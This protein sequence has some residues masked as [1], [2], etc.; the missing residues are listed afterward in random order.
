MQVCFLIES[1]GDLLSVNTRY[2]NG[3]ESIGAAP[4]AARVRHVS[5]KNGRRVTRG[6]PFGHDGLST[7]FARVDLIG[8]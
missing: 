5:C 4:A 6:R 1:P 7:K 8:V 3:A 2:T